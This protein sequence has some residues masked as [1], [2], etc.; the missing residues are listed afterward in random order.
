M[1]V[2]D[3]SHHLQTNRSID[4]IFNVS[5]FLL[6]HL[7]KEGE[8]KKQGMIYCFTVDDDFLPHWMNREKD[9]IFTLQQN[10]PKTN[11]NLTQE[12]DMI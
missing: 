10:T 12:C 6:H 9:N 11:I 2:K 5:Q 8:K 7:L 3:I 1:L 4:W